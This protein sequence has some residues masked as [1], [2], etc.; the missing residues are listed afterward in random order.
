M[1]A[2]NLFSCPKGG[3]ESLGT[4]SSNAQASAHGWRGRARPRGAHARAAGSLPFW[5]KARWASPCF[6][7]RT[8]PHQPQVPSL[9]RECCFC[10][11]TEQNVHLL[12][13]SRVQQG[14]TGRG[15]A[16]KARPWGLQP[17]PHSNRR[18]YLLPPKHHLPASPHRILPATCSQGSHCPSFLLNQYTF[19]FSFRFSEKQQG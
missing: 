11:A 1:G 17:A 2:L 9:P 7:Q 6:Q 12:L 15:S 19:H 16:E 5:I 10:G 4:C 3:S 18:G 8:V 13:G 14:S